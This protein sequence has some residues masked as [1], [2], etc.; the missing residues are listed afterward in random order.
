MPLYKYVCLDCDKEQII[1]HPMQQAEVRCQHC[2]SK[3]LK[4][5]FKTLS[6]PIKNT[7]NVTGQLV[8]EYI[9]DSKQDLKQ[10]I[11]DLKDRK[12]T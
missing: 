4:K 11:E 2:E 12:Y 10:Q 5:I 3:N 8:E 6:K 7:T 1:N 9:K